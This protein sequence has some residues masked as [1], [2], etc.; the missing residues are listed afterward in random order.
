M[1]FFRCRAFRIVSMQQAKRRRY[2]QRCCKIRRG[3]Y[4]VNSTIYCYLN[5]FCLAGFQPEIRNLNSGIYYSFT[6]SLTAT[7]GSTEL[8]RVLQKLYL[9]P[10]LSTADHPRNLFLI[11]DGH[12]TEE[13]ITLDLVRRHYQS[14]RLFTFGVGQ[15][16]NTCAN[17]K[18]YSLIII[19]VDLP[20]Q[21]RA[22]TPPNKKFNEQTA[23]VTD[24][25]TFFC[26]SLHLQ[27]CGVL[28][29][30]ENVNND[31]YFFVFSFAIERWRCI[32][33]LSKF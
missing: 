25:C 9:V 5:T 7:R 32:L 3:K 21:S 1:L 28:R 6:Q 4:A 17:C 16:V 22:K 15:V 14:D 10:A 26:L 8:W 31:G 24:R 19:L 2:T 13:D 27:Q 33:K 29:I 20:L 12:V 30:L 23:C 11:S 18:G